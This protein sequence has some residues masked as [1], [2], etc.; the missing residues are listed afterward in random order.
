MKHCKDSQLSRGSGFDIVAP[1]NFRIPRV[2]D[3]VLISATY[4]ARH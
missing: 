2:I 4:G 3:L 1:V